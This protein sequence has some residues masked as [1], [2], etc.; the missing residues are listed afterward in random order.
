[1][2]KPQLVDP[3]QPPS[4]TPFAPPTL[5]TL[6][7]Q[8]AA[9]AAERERRRVLPHDVIDLLRRA[10]VGALRL[11]RDVGGGGNSV[12]ELLATV[13]K[14]GTADANV[15]HILRNHFTVVER[16]LRIP[17]DAQSRLWQEA[18]A[19]G[20]VIG[21]A[22]TELASPKVGAVIPDTILEPQGEDYVLKGTKYYSTGTLFSDYVFVRF[23][24]ADGQTGAALIPT[25]R[26]G[27]ELVD[28]WDGIGQRLT[29]SGTTHFRGVV[30]KRTEIVIDT[31]TSGYGVPYSNT[32]A[33]LYLTTVNAGIL[34]AIEREAVELVRKRHRTFYYAPAERAAEDPVLQQTV[35][36]ISAAAFAARSAV[37][38]AAEALDVATDA[39]DANEASAY[40]ASHRAALAAAQAKIIVDRL[41]LQAGSELFDVGGASAAERIRNLDRHWRNARTLS[42]HNPTT[43]KARSI[44]DYLVN[45]TALPAKG[46]F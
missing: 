27:I 2:S 41:A 8:I 19:Q 7:D 21:L 36:N 42:S 6:F 43:L 25:K 29:G 23:A 13:V 40:D 1:M 31:P 44:G 45:G 38:E 33:Q 4:G 46:F 30:V 9:G 32:F 20:A 28:D 11:P 18:V 12:R 17:K 24:T 3:F 16:L 5:Q 26:A 37:L 22:T 39:H 35:G 15:A 14:L 10:R 34:Q